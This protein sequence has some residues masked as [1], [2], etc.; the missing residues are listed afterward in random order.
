MTTARPSNDGRSVLCGGSRDCGFVLAWIMEPNEHLLEK[1][2]FVWFPPGWVWQPDGTWILSARARRRL[3]G[4]LRHPRGQTPQAMKELSG[5]QVEGP[6]GWKPYLPAMVC[7]PDCGWRQR[8]DAQ[9]LGVPAVV[10]AMLRS[11]CSFPGCPRIVE[12]KVKNGLLVTSAFCQ[13]HEEKATGHRPA[14]KHAAGYVR[15]LV[16]REEL[17]R[18]ERERPR[19]Q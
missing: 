1:E 5:H 3:R 13:E 12:K 7:C 10:D 8:L 19:F 4:D 6:T 17:Q 2:R 18:W 16:S 11:P 14:D 9:I 15:V